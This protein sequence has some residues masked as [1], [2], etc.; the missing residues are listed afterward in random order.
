MKELGEGLRDLK[1]IGTPQEDQQNQL[2][3]ALRG[4]QRLNHKPKS[5]DRLDLDPAPM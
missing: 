4:S 3:R 5:I 1:K 2:N